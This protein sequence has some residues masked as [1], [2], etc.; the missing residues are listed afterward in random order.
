MAAL[1]R[2]PFSNRPKLIISNELMRKVNV[3]HAHIGSKEW[4][5]ELITREEGRITDLEHWTI[6][7]EDFYLVDIGSGVYTEYEVGKGAFSGPDVIE[8]FELFPGLEEG[9]H[10]RQHCHSHHTMSTFFSGEDWKNLE[11]RANNANYALMLIVNMSG[12]WEAKVAFKGVREP[13]KQSSIRLVN[14]L[15]NYPVMTTVGFEGKEYLFTMD[16]DIVIPAAEEVI[17]DPFIS[18]INKVR[19]LSERPTWGGSAGFGG[20]LGGNVSIPNKGDELTEDKQKPFWK[21]TEGEW[22]E[23]NSKDDTPPVIE[24]RH[25]RAF[26]NY[27]INPIAVMNSPMDFTDPLKGIIQK[28]RELEKSKNYK[29][30]LDAFMEYFS[31]GLSAWFD[32]RLAVR[33]GD[34][35]ADIDDYVRFCEKVKEVIKF[36][37]YCPLVALM[38]AEI[39]TEIEVNEQYNYGHSSK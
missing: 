36:S 13:E 18:R 37:S 38:I 11:N 14:N 9:T 10:K 8:L 3:L 27:Y 7:A 39:E 35:A 32:E 34:A 22:K 23:Y 28:S 2:F 25:A 26:L 29:E 1:E 15:D 4:S 5:G 19:E 17:V 6:Y 21:M 31:E 20:G 33:A 16:C 12:K 24:D 30:A